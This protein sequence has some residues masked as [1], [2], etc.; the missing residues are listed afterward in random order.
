MASQADV[1]RFFSSRLALSKS[2]CD[3]ISALGRSNQCAGALARPT[4]LDAVTCE[5]VQRWLA[6]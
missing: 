3:C 5:Q 2:C 1:A 4:L 6:E